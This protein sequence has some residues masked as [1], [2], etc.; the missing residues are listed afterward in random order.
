MKNTFRVGPNATPSFS[1]LGLRQTTT[2]EQDTLAHNALLICSL[3][4]HKCY[5]TLFVVYRPTGSQKRPLRTWRLEVSV[6]VITASKVQVP[7]M[8][9][10]TLEGDTSINNSYCFELSIFS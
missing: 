5:I 9:L 4:T 8:P 7:I 6:G 3:A 10:M 2:N 1:I